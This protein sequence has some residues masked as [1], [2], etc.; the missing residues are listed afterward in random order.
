MLKQLLSGYLGYL[1]FLPPSYD[2]SSKLKK[3]N[4]SFALASKHAL[5]YIK[6]LC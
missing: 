4:L 6:T 5:K 2:Q 1:I 3:T